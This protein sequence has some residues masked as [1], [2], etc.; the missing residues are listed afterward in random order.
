MNGVLRGRAAALAR[1]L[2]ERGTNRAA[3]TPFVLLVV[4]LLAGGLITL[5]VLNSSL[6]EGSFQVSRLKKQS[7]DLTDEQQELQRDVDAYSAPDALARR[8]AELGMV[9]GGD[10]AFL[11]PDGTVR[12]R[13][14]AAP[15]VALVR[16]S[17]PEQ[18]APKPSPTPT[19]SP[20]TSP[21]PSQSPSTS[22]SPNPGSGSTPGPGASISP[23]PTPTPY[24]SP[25]PTPGR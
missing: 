19:A 1:L 13:A 12:G 24:T 8:A 4:V 5:L 17:A 22:Q 14:S 20:S 10:P 23:S 18:P 2:P 7:T 9:P 6:N 3:R 11:A 16:P 25:D 21:S 15:P